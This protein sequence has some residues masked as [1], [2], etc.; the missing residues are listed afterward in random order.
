[1]GTQGLAGF[2]ANFGICLRSHTGGSQKYPLQFDGH[3]TLRLLAGCS[4]DLPAILTTWACFG[5]LVSV[6][7]LSDLFWM[8]NT[9]FYVDHHLQA[10][11]FVR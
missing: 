3:G 6:T 10:S 9:R 11:P 7:A 2:G 4:I 8:D 1:V 5:I